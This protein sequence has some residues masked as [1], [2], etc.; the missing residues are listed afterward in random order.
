MIYLENRSFDNLYGLFP[1]AEGVANAGPTGTQV[2]KE[3]KPYDKL[4]PV[5]NTNM[6]PVGVK[7]PDFPWRSITSPIAPTNTSSW[8]RSPA[9]PGIAITR[10]NCRSTAARWTNTSPGRTRRR[11]SWAITTVRRRRSGNWRRTTR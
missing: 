1:G 8:N 10:N 3:G 6:K 9:T 11:W 7:T 4:P 5:L 2:D